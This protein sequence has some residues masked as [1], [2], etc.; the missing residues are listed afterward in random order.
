MI[1]EDSVCVETPGAVKEIRDLRGQL[2]RMDARGGKINKPSLF[3]LLS[4]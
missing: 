1:S 2:V 4:S 3:C